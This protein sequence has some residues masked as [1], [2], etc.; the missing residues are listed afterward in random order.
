MRGA[1]FMRSDCTVVSATLYVFV[2]NIA[3]QSFGK[4]Y[5]MY[6]SALKSLQVKHIV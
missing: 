5:V 3:L 4:A 6:N 1:F 2:M